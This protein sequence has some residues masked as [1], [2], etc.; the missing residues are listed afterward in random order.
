MKLGDFKNSN[1]IAEGEYI[2]N[3]SALKVKEGT[4]S[5]VPFVILD[6]LAVEGPGKGKHTEVTFSFSEKSRSFARAWLVAVGCED[7]ED[8]PIQDKEDLEA[9][10]N[11]RMVGK[12][13][14]C[15]LAE[16]TDNN[17]YKKNN[18]TPPWEV[19]AAEAPEGFASET[20]EEPEW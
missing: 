3:I 2:L 7:D 15:K 17:G 19:H 5:G 16:E 14:S 4:D 8:I 13:V 20:T 6:V 1:T 12:C 18:V 10:L 9:F 11:A